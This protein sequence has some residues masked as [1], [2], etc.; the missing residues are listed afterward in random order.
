[1][2]FPYAKRVRLAADRY[3]NREHVFHVVV[4]ATP[5][6]VPFRDAVG[7][8]VWQAVLGERK[9]A[10]VSLVAACLMPD[11]L[12]VLV[13]PGDRSVLAWVDAF[14]SYATH[15]SGVVGGP[16]YLWQP[17]FYDRLI[18]NSREFDA[19]VAY[20]VGNPAAEG[21]VDDGSEWPWVYVDGGPS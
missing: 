4:R 18:R 20:V 15:V 10:S 2:D 14:K 16:P 3:A 12:H 7:R 11:H 5:G 1:M 13:K 8:A 19:A 9:R 17:G 6:T 21:L